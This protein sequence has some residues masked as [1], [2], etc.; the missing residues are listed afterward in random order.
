MILLALVRS[1]QKLNCKRAQVGFTGSYFDMRIRGVQ[2]KNDN[3]EI[4]YT[5]YLE[6]FASISTPTGNIS[7]WIKTGI[8]MKSD[9]L[10][11]ENKKHEIQYR[12]VN[13]WKSKAY[14]AAEKKIDNKWANY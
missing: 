1:A 9:A 10:I 11:T 13:N 14:S 7:Q 12:R 3:G 4:F 8:E 2:Q 5:G 6:V